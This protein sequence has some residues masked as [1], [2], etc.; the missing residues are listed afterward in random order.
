MLQ[1]LQ[2]ATGMLQPATG[3]LQDRYRTCS[4]DRA[5]HRPLATSSAIGDRYRWSCSQR[6]LTQ[7]RWWV[8]KM[9]PN[10]PWRP[11]VSLLPPAPVPYR[12]EEIDGIDLEL[13]EQAVEETDPIERRATE[14]EEAA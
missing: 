8:S 1:Q 5:R 11:S 3:P 4:Q 12:M 14:C 9:Q 2:A 13:R 10:D 7:T 6:S